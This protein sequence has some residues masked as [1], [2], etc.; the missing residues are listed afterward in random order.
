MVRAAANTG[1]VWRAAATT[2]QTPAME[3]ITRAMPRRNLTSAQK[4]RGRGRAVTGSSL[5]S[6]SSPIAR[7]RAE[8]I[9]SL[10]VGRTAVIGTHA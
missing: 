9:H 5:M 2:D 8:V 1:A 4:A 3:T 10:G 7:S 6:S